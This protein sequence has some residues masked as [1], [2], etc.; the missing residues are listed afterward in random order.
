MTLPLPDDGATRR[1]GRC[2]GEHAPQGLLVKLGGPLGAGKTTL[3][4]GLAEGLDVPAN[5]QVRSPSYALMRVHEGGRLPLVH[6]DFYRLTEP[7]ELLELGLEEWLGD[8]AVVAV[9]WADRFPDELP[10]DGL[11]I[12]LAYPSRGEGRDATLSWPARLADHPI[13]EGLGRLERNDD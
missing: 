10:S 5:T 6:V 4:Q 8:R 9:E 2:V 7:D 13:V 11:A 3:V 12:D 1:L